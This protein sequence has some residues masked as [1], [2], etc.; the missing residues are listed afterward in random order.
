M[1]WS[2]MDDQEPVRGQLNASAHDLFEQPEDWTDPGLY[3]VAPGVHRIPL[4]LPQDGLVAVN[5]YAIETHDGLVLVDGGWAL[6]LSRQR[7][8]AA[9][10]E[11]DRHVRDITRFLITHV[12]RDHYT[13]AVA[14]RREFPT[15]I[16]VGKGE[17]PTLELLTSG[18]FGSLEPQHKQLR[19]AGAEPLLRELVRAGLGPERKSSQPW[20]MP[21]DWLDAPSVIG[22]PSGPDLEV[23]HCPGHTQGHVVFVDRQ[24]ELL[25]AGD[26]VLP[27]ITPSIGYEASPGEFPLDDYLA[28][29]RM[30]LALPD[31]RLLPAHGP[32][33]TSVHARV[34]EL[35]QH[36]DD[37]LDACLAAAR[38]GAETAYAVA[39]AL[40]WTRRRR[41]FG[42]LD[43][44]NKM[45]ATIE[46]QAHLDVAA[47]QGRLTRTEVDG[48][49]HY[50]TS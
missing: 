40:S 18:E 41:R 1:I 49:T 46:T 25:F 42:D 16:S 14:L 22:L 32:V 3:P 10:A 28:S 31:L 50:A 4:P 20:E 47:T 43:P 24:A 27:H 35:L 12:H 5:V 44:F 13:Q 34:N 30:M 9:L 26:H 7:L 37:R 2:F 23:L 6:E 33:T 48:S 39:K 15:R 21:D 38:E 17:R 29:L 45:L 19:R 11:I 8:D 36:H